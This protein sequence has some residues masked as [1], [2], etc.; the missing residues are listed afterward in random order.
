MTRE[1]GKN[2]FSGNVYTAVVQLV[3]LYGMDTLDIT[4]IILGVL[5]NIHGL[6]KGRDQHLEGI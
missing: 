6:S 2:W 4:G 1:G 3:L 5:E